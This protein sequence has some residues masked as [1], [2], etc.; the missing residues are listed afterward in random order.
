MA[1]QPEVIFQN[2]EIYVGNPAN[3]KTLFSELTPEQCTAVE[4]LLKAK[5]TASNHDS[6]SINIDEESPLLGP[7]N[8]DTAPAGKRIDLAD[9]LNPL[10]HGFRF[11]NLKETKED[12]ESIINPAEANVTV[13][14][15]N[16]AE[17]LNALQNS[18][19]QTGHTEKVEKILQEFI[20]AILAG[21]TAAAPF[22]PA[23]TAAAQ[24]QTWEEWGKQK[25]IVIAIS[26]S[27]V[28]AGVYAGE[29]GV[30]AWQKALEAFNSNVIGGVCTFASVVSNFAQIYTNFEKLKTDVL[31]KVSTFL[32]KIT[33]PYLKYLS[34]A[35]LIP[36]LF[37]ISS[38]TAMPVGASVLTAA[39]TLGEASWLAQGSAGL[40]F[41]MRSLLVLRGICNLSG[42]VTDKLST[43]KASWGNGEYAKMFSALIGLSVGAGFGGLYSWNQKGTIPPYFATLV[44]EIF[45]TDIAVDGHGAIALSWMGF[46]GALAL[47]FNY[48]G[49]GA[50]R[51]MELFTN[52]PENSS[53][54]LNILLIALTTG[55]PGVALIKTQGSPEIELLDKLDAFL[56]AAL[57]NYA[58]IL[59]LGPFR[60][61]TERTKLRTE[62]N[63]TANLFAALKKYAELTGKAGEAAYYNA[64]LKASNVLINK[65]DALQPTSTI[66]KV[67]RSVGSSVSYLGSCLSGAFN[68]VGTFAS[69]SF[70]ALHGCQCDDDHESIIA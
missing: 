30:L 45:K 27:L 12:I 58:S 25:L 70:G 55:F 40:M 33:N 26:L 2:F 57:S 16:L 9:T 35:L 46:I 61:A 29:Y 11:D 59:D 66:S 54:R 68:T 3:K 44:Q 20:R 36:A 64:L 48:V 18:F 41:F 56:A 24:A 43:V 49:D 39:T 47:N 5:K 13:T 34:G 19:A 69:Q 28:G 8:G 63:E 52:N 15:E 38:S 65:I 42:S 17:I 22:N 14:A 31:G 51:L 62:F 7:L 10:L 23:N 21:G 53:M 67:V 60:D 37:I 6:M 4:N 50:Q 32:D 1:F